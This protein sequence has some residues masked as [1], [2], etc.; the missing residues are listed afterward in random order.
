MREGGY[1]SF[2]T[3]LW[4]LRAAA[5]AGLGA[6]EWRRSGLLTRLGRLSL[7]RTVS[8]CSFSTESAHGPQGTSVTAQA[9]VST[10]ATPQ[11]AA[12]VCVFQSHHCYPRARILRRRR[13]GRLDQ[14]LSSWV[15][16]Y[17]VVGVSSGREGVGR[18]GG[19]RCRCF[20]EVVQDFAAKVPSV[21]ETR[22][23]PRRQDIS[24]DHSSAFS[25]HRSL[26]L[27][28]TIVLL[29]PTVDISP[30]AADAFT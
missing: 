1:G 14:Y 11:S 28:T 24:I 3:H 10:P 30:G 25:L 15:E 6:R 4:L 8:H 26:A 18:R 5:R 21:R 27:L 17:H 29:L 22:P 7:R 20:R 9:I 13:G 23:L 19:L 12:A 2:A 16:A